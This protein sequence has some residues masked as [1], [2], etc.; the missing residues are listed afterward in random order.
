MGSILALFAIIY[1]KK[2]KKPNVLTS[3]SLYRDFDRWIMRYLAKL[4]P[5]AICVSHAVKTELRSMNKKI[6]T[7]CIPNGFDGI[8]PNGDDKSTSITKQPD[9]LLIG[10]V[11]RLSGK[12]SVIDFINIATTLVQKY[13]FLKFVIVGD[14]PQRKYLQRKSKKLSTAKQIVFTGNLTRVGVFDALKQMDIF[15]L[16][17]PHEA[18][19]MVLLEAISHKI[20]IVA[21]DN[22]GVSDII[23]AHKTGYLANSSQMMVDYLSQL[24]ENPNL[25]SEIATNAYPL[26]AKFQWD[27]T[28]KKTVAV[29]RNLISQASCS[30]Q[31]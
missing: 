28:A 2:I 3:H 16:T 23:T 4:V 12:K 26:V 7:Y 15:V 18:F 24:I 17:S 19:G 25:R 31:D 11:S 30:K 21:R 5:H 6:H 22:N 20:P 10:T 14:G 27:E 8:S 13:P 29:Y 1:A 9:E